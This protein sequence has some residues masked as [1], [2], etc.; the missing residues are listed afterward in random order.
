MAKTI[1]G[2]RFTLAEFSGALADLG[3]MLPLI[4]AL[5]TLNKMDAAAVFFGIGLAY[6]LV[7]GTYRLPIPVQPL[8]S[9]S[10]IA[11]AQGLAPTVIVSAGIWNAVVFLGMGAARLDRWVRKVFPIP[12]VRGIQLGLAWL[13]FKSAW[14]LVRQTPD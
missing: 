14:T 12:V 7:A 8:K 9:V 10:A 1:S 5:I 4:L 11:I 6:I 13:L 3:V 2:F